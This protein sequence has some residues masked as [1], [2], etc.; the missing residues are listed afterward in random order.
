MNLSHCR[1]ALA[2]GTLLLVAGCIQGDLSI[3]A[4]KGLGAKTDLW[5]MDSQF[6]RYHIVHLRADDGDGHQLSRVPDGTMRQLPEEVGRA[7][8]GRP[9]QPGFRCLCALLNTYFHDWDRAI[10]VE[11]LGCVEPLWYGYVVLAFTPDGPKAVT[12][13]LT[14][15]HSPWGWQPGLD[16]RPLQVDRGRLAPVLADLGRARERFGGVLLCY[17]RVDA[18]LFILHDVRRN[19]EGL[20][21][22]IRGYEFPGSVCVERMPKEAEYERA[23]QVWKRQWP[24]DLTIHAPGEQWR[25]VVP[26]GSPH[27]KEIDALGLVYATLVARVWEGVL[28]LEDAT[29]LGKAGRALN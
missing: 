13:M 7:L 5:P 8:D 29:I 1:L 2:A 22:G 25:N 21:F 18:P 14:D 17:D 9:S 19:G 10:I 26:F 28:G 23:G 16:P 20:S 4:P 24:G 15:G 27:A 3:Y 12:N 11:R 6:V